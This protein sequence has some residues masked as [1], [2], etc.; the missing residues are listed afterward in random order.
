MK[1]IKQFLISIFLAISFSSFSQ[2]QLTGKIMEKEASGKESPI[3]MAGIK[4]LN[5]NLTATSDQNGDFHIP[6]PDSMPE[7]LLVR[8]IG[9]ANDTVLFKDR[10]KTFVKILLKTD[11][12][13]LNEVKVVGNQ[14]ATTHLT[15]TI[16][17]T[18]LL[19]QKELTLA[20]CCNLSESFERSA[21]VDVNFTDAVSGTKQIQMLGLDGIYTQILYENLPFV[22]GLSASQGLTYIPGPWVEKILVT[23][24]TG[25]VLNGYES[26][27]GQIQIE[28]L[29]PEQAD[30]FFLNGYASSENRFELNMHKAKKFKNHMSTVLFAHASRNDMNGETHLDRNKD[31]LLDMP[32]TEQYTVFNR[33]HYEKEGK[34]E[35][36]FGVRALME[37]KTGG[38]LSDLTDT[39]GNHYGIGINTRQLETFTKNG[40]LFPSK[41]WKSIAVMTTERYHKADAF[42]GIKKFEGEQKSLYVNTIWADII[43]NTKH[44]IKFGTSLVLD[45]FSESLFDG[46]T[47]VSD[48]IHSN[49]EIVPGGYAEYTYNNDS[50]L[51][52]VA[53]IRGDYFEDLGLMVNPRLHLK[54]NTSKESSFRL[55]GGR[56]MRTPHIFVENSSVFASSRQI[57]IAEDLH[58]EVAW[59]Y[60]MTFNYSFKPF[61]KD[62]SF[63]IDIFR[64]DFENQVVV[65]LE[66][67]DKVQF[68]NLK[69][70]SYSNSLQT[71][72]SISPLERMDVKVAY[73][74]YDVKTTY[75]GKLLDKPLVPKD[76]A[77]FTI[78]Y[79]TDR[80]KWKFSFT[81]KWFGKSR[82][83]NTSS[84][85]PE[86]QLPEHSP[87]YYTLM[88][89]VAK[90]LKWIELYLGVENLLDYRI[91][92][93]ILDPANPYGTNF[94][95]TMIWGPINGRVIYGGF[96]YR[97]I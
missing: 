38:Q 78:D 74:Y 37:N 56:G 68:D 7:K 70:L 75:S 2:E 8:M 57:V 82:L 50:N 80:E 31:G 4:W 16:L 3:G 64:T 36:Q 71:E 29:E 1:T 66:D 93:P 53:G 89:Q 79:A 55:S 87:S 24:G 62:A 45:R 49:R 39:S 23:K 17:N 69:G 43:D 35:G 72:F 97:I 40:F 76:R 54:Y 73:K 13:I 65:D 81:A 10:S 6:F 15:T 20:A 9:F 90:R 48:S 28:M 83:P 21:S 59:N 18:E 27:T 77:L 60:G 94:D 5:T 85:A 42:F 30:R 91:S 26:I 67:P 92:N 63:N 58:P 47:S 52:V 22:R 46:T 14:A 41:P 84:N 61:G 95:A 88:A 19:S 34:V 51:S 86:F 33:W 25:S 32:L 11:A 12:Q 44:K 96:R